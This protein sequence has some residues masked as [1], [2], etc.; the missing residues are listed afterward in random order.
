LLI[1]KLSWAESAVGGKKIIQWHISS[2]WQSFLAITVLVV[3]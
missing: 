1:F 3:D 2:M